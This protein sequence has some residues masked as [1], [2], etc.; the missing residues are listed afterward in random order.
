MS[1]SRT[2][3]TARF[4][5]ALPAIL[6]LVGLSACGGNTAP[7]SSASPTR[8]EAAQSAAPA[9]EDA[10]EESAVADA[11]GVP[12]VPGYAPGEIPPIPLFVVPDTSLI[13]SKDASF[14]LST[15][16]ELTSIPGVRVSPAK[17]GA[18]GLVSGATVFGPDGS[19][20]RSDGTGATINGGDGTGNYSDGSVSIINGGDGSGNYSDGSRTLIVASDGSGN[21]SDPFI[22][23]VV[24][25]DGS[26]NYS[27]SQTGQ[28]IIVGGDGSGSYSAGT[29][30]ITNNGDG[31]GTYAGPG[32]SIVN[33]GEGQATVN[34]TLIDAKPLPP[35]G[36]IG[37]MAPVPAI[38]PVKACGTLITLE[39]GVL[40]DFGKSEIRPDARATIDKVAQVFT[41]L[42]V[43]AATVTGHTDSV[44]DEA[45]NLT[46]SQERADAV[47]T[48]M[49]GAG[50]TANLTAEGKGESQ[51][52]AANENPDGSDNPAGRQLNRRV[53]IFVPSF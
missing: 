24:G 48:A 34:G 6:A 25:A 49:Q 19:A 51:P 36:K 29:V 42:K 4:A 3:V 38:A 30:A 26:G 53:E 27:N 5:L 21:Y 32:L 33:D 50:V 18:S 8:T 22:T 15:T 28:T 41:T 13:S 12:A 9:D 2:P 47:V 20:N 7:N 23:V 39:D 35:V 43:P 16:T 46:L 14:D 1:T 40:F 11:A 44:S 45:F 10:A 52:V 37:K 17:C 31:S